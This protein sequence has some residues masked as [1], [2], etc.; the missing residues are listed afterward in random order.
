[1]SE[2]ADTWFLIL[3]ADELIDGDR[4][5]EWLT[6]TDVLSAHDVVE[7]AAYNYG[8]NPSHRELQWSHAG[9]LIRQHELQRAHLLTADDR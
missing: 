9:L 5:A 4:L 2:A 1:M 7:L 3:D 8:T 6:Q